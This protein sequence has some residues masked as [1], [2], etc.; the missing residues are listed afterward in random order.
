MNKKE[1]GKRLSVIRKKKKMALEELSNKLNID[2]KIIIDWET[3]KLLP[4]MYMLKKICLVYNIEIDELVSSKQ[5]L[6]NI[7]KSKS[8][9]IFSI[10]IILLLIFIMIVLGDIIL[11]RPVKISDIN[12]FIFEGESDNFLFRDGI[13]IYSEDKKYIELS[14]F[15]VKDNLNIKSMTVNIA[16]N[17]TIWGVKE[18]EYSKE[19]SSR[20]WLNKLK[21]NEYSNIV[22]EEDK[23]DKSKKYDSFTKYDE[24]NFPYDFKVE[25][26]YCTDVICTVEIIDVETKKLDVTNE[27][28]V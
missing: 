21:F 3:G 1:L 20:E 5:L 14:N 19:E 8:K 27:I 28:N 26:N 7:L 23:H 10:I 16:F 13:F 12:V 25:I 4:S 9:N 18:Y 2:E 17:E 6:D 11:N 15:S 22:S 24:S